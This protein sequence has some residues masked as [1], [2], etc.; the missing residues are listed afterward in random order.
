M[1]RKTHESLEDR[2]RLDS[3][4]LRYSYFVV[5]CKLVPILYRH[6]NTIRT[7]DDEIRIEVMHSCV[8]DIPFFI[9]PRCGSRRRFLY[10]PGLVCRDCAKIN[11][12]IQQRGHGDR[13]NAEEFLNQHLSGSEAR[14]PGMRMKR[15]EKLIRRYRKHKDAA[16][17]RSEKAFERFIDSGWMLAMQDKAFAEAWEKSTNES[18]NNVF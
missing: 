2:E 12:Q 4:D 1:S 17:E 16:E 7:P 13:R 9:C 10:Y 11:Y 8:A 18:Y 15:Y 14:P 3:L 5:G 6:G